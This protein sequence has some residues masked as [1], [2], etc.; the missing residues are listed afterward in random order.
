MNFDWDYTEVCSQ[1]S[2]TK[3]PSIGSDNGLA[4]TRH[5][6]IIWTSDGKF[7]D[8]YMRHPASM[9]LQIPNHK[10]P[11]KRWKIMYKLCFAYSSVVC[12]H[13]FWSN[14]ASHFVDIDFKHIF[15]PN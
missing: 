5:Q 1:R 10:K 9:S 15:P 7:T 13:V 8:A 11:E 6:A 3:Q 14:Q 2:T 4:P 12:F